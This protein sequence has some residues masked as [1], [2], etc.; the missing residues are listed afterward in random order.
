MLRGRHKLW[1]IN[2]KYYNAVGNQL[3]AM[4]LASPRVNELIYATDTGKPFEGVVPQHLI[5]EAG[6][7]YDS[8]GTNLDIPFTYS[9]DEIVLSRQEKSLKGPLNIRG[10]YYWCTLEFATNPTGVTGLYKINSYL[11]TDIS[12]L[13]SRDMMVGIEHNKDVVI[14]STS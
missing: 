1:K 6:A 4:A 13:P 12:R 7:A 11:E 3:A 14:T 10:L 5:Y 2:N 8:Y 9:F